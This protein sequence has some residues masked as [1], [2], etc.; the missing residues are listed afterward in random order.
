MKHLLTSS[1]LLLLLL[2]VALHG[3]GQSTQPTTNKQDT[4]IPK[5]AI[6]HFKQEI[7]R[8]KEKVHL[9]ALEIR[10]LKETAKVD[11]VRFGEDSLIVTY[12]S[13]SAKPLKIVTQ[14]FRIPQRSYNDSIVIYFNKDGLIEYKEMWH[15]HEKRKRPS[16]EEFFQERMKLTYRR[17]EYDDQNRLIRQVVHYPTP[18]TIEYT[19]TYDSSGNQATHSSRFNHLDFWDSPGAKSND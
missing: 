3:L 2:L 8:Y 7:Y 6:G 17:Y 13:A 1:K 18:R 16:S 15:I 11:S 10:V 9:Q 12:T 14:K 5:A 4:T 19:Y